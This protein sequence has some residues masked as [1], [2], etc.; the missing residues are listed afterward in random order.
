MKKLLFAYAKTKGADQLR[1]NRTADQRHC[2][3]YI[4]NT[5]PLNLKFQD[6]SHQTSSVAVQPG[7]CRTWSET[8][9]Q[10]FSRLRSFIELYYL[11][12]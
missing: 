2:F 4:D 10:V 6:S 3:R 1:N 9:R 5:I 12:F 8:Q 7:L 11:F